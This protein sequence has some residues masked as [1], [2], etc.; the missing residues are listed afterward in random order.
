MQ[1]LTG[2]LGCLLLICYLQQTSIAAPTHVKRNQEDTVTLL[3][4]GYA[5]RVLKAAQLVTD[6]L[7]VSLYCAENLRV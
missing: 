7:N 4:N 6:K 3:F 2:L 1:L 5:C